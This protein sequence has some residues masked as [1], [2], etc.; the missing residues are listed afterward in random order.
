MD[1][2]LPDLGTPGRKRTQGGQGKGCGRTGK[3]RRHHGEKPV[4][5]A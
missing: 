3:V 4:P 2:H 1:G 5:D